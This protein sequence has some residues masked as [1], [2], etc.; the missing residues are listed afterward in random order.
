VDHEGGGV[1][2]EPAETSRR[3]GWRPAGYGLGGALLA[4]GLAG[5]VTDTRL[6][7]LFGWALW[8]GGLIAAHDGVLVPLVVAAG[9]LTGAVREPYRFWARAASAV[10]ALLC[11]M[12]LPMVLGIG[13]RADNPSQLPLDYGRNLLL[14]VGLIAA[15][16]VAAMATIWLR[17]VL[18]RWPRRG[19]HDV[20]T[21]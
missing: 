8:F 20:R 21:R 11:L 5:L 6:T 4:T 12:A 14:V 2:S 7:D 16:A 10:A 3:L 13:R 15:T 18:R 19:G 9:V 17:K 1:V